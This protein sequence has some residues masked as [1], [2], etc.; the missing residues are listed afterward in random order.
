[1]RLG[2][3]RYTSGRWRLP[4]LAISATVAGN[5]ERSARYVSDS[6]SFSPAFFKRRSLS[7]S[8]MFHITFQKE[9][10]PLLEKKNGKS[11]EDEIPYLIK[12]KDI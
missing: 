3:A 6:R 11:F 9:Y 10:I 7:I 8:G 12:F 2:S 5:F 1:M 4:D